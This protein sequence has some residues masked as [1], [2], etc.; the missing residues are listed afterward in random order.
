MPP[1]RIRRKRKARLKPKSQIDKDYRRNRF[2]RETQGP[3]IERLKELEPK[4]SGGLMDHELEGARREM[5]QGIVSAICEQLEYAGKRRNES[6][7]PHQLEGRVLGRALI[8]ERVM[9][10]P[11]SRRI[12]LFREFLGWM[13]A[14][15]P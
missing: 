6:L 5:C 12:P 7:C 1:V 8:V 2:F 3:I 9:R 15:A 11:I 10:Y 4:N 13:L 14:I